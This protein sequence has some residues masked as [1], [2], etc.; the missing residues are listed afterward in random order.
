MA[1]Y[2]RAA[3]QGENPFMSEGTREPELV[4][5]GNVC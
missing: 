1:A 5:V 3:W 2:A 4:E